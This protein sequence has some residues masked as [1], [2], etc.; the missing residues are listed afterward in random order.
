MIAVVFVKY[1]KN[2][3]DKYKVVS[4]AVAK[5]YNDDSSVTGEALYDKINGTNT[6]VLAHITMTSDLPNAKGVSGNYGYVVSAP[7]YSKID[8]TKVIGY[9]IWDGK[10]TT[11][12]YDENNGTTAVVKGDVITFDNLGEGNVDNVKLAQTK[13]NKLIIDSVA[14]VEGQTFTVT[15]DSTKTYIIT[16]KTTVLYVDSDDYAGV[17]SGSVQQAADEIGGSAGEKVKN[18]AYVVSEKDGDNANALKLDLL[19]VEV[20]GDW[21]TH[22]PTV[23]AVTS[24]AS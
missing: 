5:H 3:V 19:V 10:N 20:N 4:G 12:I 13:D 8:G 14:G 22:A 6:V 1:Q 15:S 23:P 7:F 24:P 21:G 16:D 18:I 17:E 2:G 9:E 11:T